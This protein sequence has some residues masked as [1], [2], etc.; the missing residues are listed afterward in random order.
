MHATAFPDRKAD[1]VAESRINDIMLHF[2]CPEV[3]TSDN[4]VEYTNNLMRTVN[5]LLHIRHHFTVPYN[6]QANGKVEKRNR[7]LM[8]T[9]T[10]FANANQDDW[11]IYLPVA[12]WSYNTTV[13]SATGYTPFRAVFGREAR[14]PA[15]SW[16]EDFQQQYCRGLDDLVSKVTQNL[17]DIWWDITKRTYIIHQKEDHDRPDN[18]HQRPFRPYRRGEQFFFKTVPCRN[19]KSLEDEQLYKI[20]AKLQYRFS[21]PHVVT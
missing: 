15:D 20:S 7:T 17:R 11:D 9:L 18:P 12:T 5:A 4:G 2:G 6:P 21:G 14:S 19:F 13:N 16:I 10:Q 8:V 3:V 1:T